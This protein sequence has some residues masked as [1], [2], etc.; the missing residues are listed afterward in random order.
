MPEH[1]EYGPNAEFFRQRFAQDND[2]PE[3]IE[4]LLEIADRAG[5]VYHYITCGAVSNPDTP[6]DDIIAI[7]DRC[8]F[9]NIDQAILAVL[10]RIIDGGEDPSEIAQEFSGDVP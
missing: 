6:A 4:Y 2:T 5:E 1:Y 8:T 10:S 7:S 3:M 9:N